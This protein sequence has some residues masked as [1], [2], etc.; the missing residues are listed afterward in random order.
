MPSLAERW[1]KEGIEK[2]V[3]KGKREDIVRLYKK[4]NLS[5]EK[6]SE[7][8]EIEITKV[9]KIL[10]EEGFFENNSR[11]D[12]PIFSPYKEMFLAYSF[13]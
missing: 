6:I 12:I 11:I 9:K 3:E 8:L 10:K 7:V 1:Y 5:P 4:L 13:L 2:G